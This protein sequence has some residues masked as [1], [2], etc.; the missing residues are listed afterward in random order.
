MY[1]RKVSI[2]SGKIEL[3]KNLIDS[4]HF[5]GKHPKRK[6]TPFLDL[7]LIRDW[8]SVSIPCRRRRLEMLHKSRN[9]AT[10]HNHVHNFLCGNLKYQRPKAE[11]RRK[12]PMH[13]YRTVRSGAKNSKLSESSYH[14][15]PTRKEYGWRAWRKLDPARLKRKTLQESLPEC[16]P[17]GRYLDEHPQ[18]LHGRED[19]ED[20]GDEC[21]GSLGI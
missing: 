20:R 10:I 21:E 18:V 17:H 2:N 5:Y 4:K 15:W 9:C 11:P 16:G 1:K 6:S 14:S 19:Q 3:I 13:V 12:I 8:A 7:V